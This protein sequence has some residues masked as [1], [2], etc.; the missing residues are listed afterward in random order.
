MTEAEAA[1]VA[2]WLAAAADYELSAYSEPELTRDE[3][4]WF[5]QFM[6]LSGQPG[7]HFTVVLEE[8]SRESRI[9]RG[10]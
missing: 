9:I 6:G 2:R 4:T 10:R 3:Q 7:D 8:P 1:E 5:F